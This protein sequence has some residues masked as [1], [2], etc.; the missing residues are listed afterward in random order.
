MKLSGLLW[1]NVQLIPVKHFPSA[2]REI[3]KGFQDE[4]VC[5]SVTSLNTPDPMVNITSEQVL[6]H[7]EEI[8]GILEKLPS[9]AQLETWFRKMGCKIHIEELGIQDSIIREAMTYAPYVSRDITL[10]RLMK[11]FENF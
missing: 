1:K 10:L 9:A 6:Q 5:E 4:E 3:Q 2:R 11:L 7:R 8:L